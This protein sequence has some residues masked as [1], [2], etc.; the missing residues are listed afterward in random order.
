[1][2]AARYAKGIVLVAGAAT[3][4]ITAY[5]GTREWAPLAIQGITALVAILVPNTEK[6]NPTP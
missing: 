2:I 5:Y 4:V 3:S 1:M 6:G